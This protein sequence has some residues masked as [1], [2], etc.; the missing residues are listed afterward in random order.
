MGHSQRVRCEAIPSVIFATM[1][2]VGMDSLSLPA[3]EDLGG[4]E[5]SIPHAHLGAN[6]DAPVS[7][8]A[9]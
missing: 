1:T 5:E 9:G 8:D 4:E 2:S 6:G 3:I 7:V